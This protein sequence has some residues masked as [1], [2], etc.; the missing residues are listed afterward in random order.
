GHGAASG[1]EG[2]GGRARLRGRDRVE[3]AAML[4]PAGLD[5][6]EAR[7][8][9]HLTEGAFGYFSDAARADAA[10]AHT[11]AVHNALAWRRWYLRPR[12]LVD[13]SAADTA[14]PVLGPPA[15]PPVR[16]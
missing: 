14:T 7:A 8:R 13:V 3:C 9:E 11:T 16:P 10:E 15:R 2:R 4:L 1:G 5:Q 6:L 12:V